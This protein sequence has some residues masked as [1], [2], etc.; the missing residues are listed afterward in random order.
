MAKMIPERPSEETSSAAERKLF[1]R[2]KA[3]PDTED[4]VVLHSLAIAKHMTQSQGEADFA[5]V[6]PSYGV[7]V[8]EV[9][10]GRISYNN[11]TWYKC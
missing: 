10:G 4:W 11:G 1:Q 7:F 8:L 5:V 2:F 9:K 6:I 3:M